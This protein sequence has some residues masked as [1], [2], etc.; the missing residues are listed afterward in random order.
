MEF[1]YIHYLVFLALGAGMAFFIIY[2]IY[3]NSKDV[4]KW[5]LEK[6]HEED[7][8]PYTNVSMDLKDVHLGISLDDEKEVQDPYSHPEA[9]SGCNK[10]G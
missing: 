4:E 8:D 7:I 9:E 10:N 6:D 3:F 2:I 5:H 1:L